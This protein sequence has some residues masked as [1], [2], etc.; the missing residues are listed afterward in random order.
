[1]NKAR[2]TK[3]S[4]CWRIKHQKYV[5]SKHTQQS[6]DDDDDDDTTKGGIQTATECR[7][8]EL[9]FKKKKRS[10]MNHFL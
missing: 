2:I 1:L 7:D 4:C 3:K 8:A 9:K 6:N 5:H 10:K